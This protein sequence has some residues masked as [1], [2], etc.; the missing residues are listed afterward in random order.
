MAEG[1]AGSSSEWRRGRSSPRLA[2][3]RVHDFVPC[4]NAFALLAPDSDDEGG[5]HFG[6]DCGTLRADGV[7][8]QEGGVEPPFARGGLPTA[9]PPEGEL[10]D[11]FVGTLR[12]KVKGRGAA[13]VGRLAIG[14]VLCSQR[15]CHQRGVRPRGRRRSERRLRP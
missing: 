9:P 2:S 7:A 8:G 3:P 4:R 14:G 11:L 13:D 6:A 15:R 5:E 1:L 10:G 12:G